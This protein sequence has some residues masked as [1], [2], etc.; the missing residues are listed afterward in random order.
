MAKKR[1][2]K[3]KTE[4][5]PEPQVQE[6]PVPVQRP[7]N[8]HPGQPRQIPGLTGNR[9]NGPG[10]QRQAMFATGPT[11]GRLERLRAVIAA[12]AVEQLGAEEGAEPAN[13][14]AL[15][16]AAAEVFPDVALSLHLLEAVKTKSGDLDSFVGHLA[17]VL[18]LVVN[19]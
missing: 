2:A 8:R 14:D 18:V 17:A 4:A 12:K 1:P 3:P 9:P 15:T 5:A 11:G 6:T 7:V 10:I 16:A 19:V 13:L